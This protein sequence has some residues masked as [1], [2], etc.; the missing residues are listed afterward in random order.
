M[1][2]YDAWLAMEKVGRYIVTFEIILI[3]TICIISLLLYF[4]EK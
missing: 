3:L 2:Q 4:L 1:W